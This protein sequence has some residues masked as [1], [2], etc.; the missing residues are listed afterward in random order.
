MYPKGYF[1]MNSY[2][3]LINVKFNGNFKKFYHFGY[4]LSLTYIAFYVIPHVYGINPGIY[5]MEYFELLFDNKI[6]NREK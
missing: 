1:F 6:K 2:F 5:I 4:K 3:K